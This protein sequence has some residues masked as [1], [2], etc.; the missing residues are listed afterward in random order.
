MADTT[1]KFYQMMYNIETDDEYVLN[2]LVECGLK[3]EYI[4]KY[5]VRNEVLKDFRLSCRVLFYKVRVED[6]VENLFRLFVDKIGQYHHGGATAG[7]E[8]ILIR[9]DDSAGAFSIIKANDSKLI[10]SK[11]SSLGIEFY[12]YEHIKDAILGADP[13]DY[14]A[15][16][17]TIERTDQIVTCVEKVDRRAYKNGKEISQENYESIHLAAI[18]KYLRLSR[19]L[20][21]DSEYYYQYG[22]EQ[23]Q[24]F[25]LYSK[26]QKE[27]LIKYV[28]KESCLEPEYVNKKGEDSRNYSQDYNQEEERVEKPKFL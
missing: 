7:S 18:G 13:G 1:E 6:N 26:E 14:I 21:C 10:A 9:I 4:T 22:G 15:V 28:Q 24:P 11:F 20:E 27:A 17:R 19:L 16:K 2:H 25:A 3:K 23:T 5:F 8:S 12:R